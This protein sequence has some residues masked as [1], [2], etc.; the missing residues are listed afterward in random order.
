MAKITVQYQ[1]VQELEGGEQKNQLIMDDKKQEE[2]SMDGEKTQ[3]EQ[4]QEVEKIKVG[5]KEYSQEE[6]SHLVGLG[7]VGAE[8]ESKWNTKIDRLY[9]E[10][11]K[12]T[13]EREDYRKKVE[14]YETSRTKA[15]V[16]A[17]EELSPEE[18][19]KQALAEA[20]KLGLVHAGN[21]YQFVDAYLQAR[22]MKEEAEAIIT[23]AE[24]TGK[25]KTTTQ[26]L[27]AYMDQTGIKNVGLAYKSKFENELDAWKQKQLDGIKSGNM[28]TLD[29][30]RAGSKQ[31]EP[32][33]LDNLDSLSA[34]MK[35]Y[36]NRAS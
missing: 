21:V 28:E 26:E 34:A 12:A 6:L 1:V 5:E 35:S 2:K 22:D 20:E 13:Q 25:P 19:Q 23:E 9:P 29:A 11:T 7:E 31:P 14:E 27:F 15:K 36:F 17:G 24:E 18:A 30:S 33:K 32:V 10:F 3:P 16:A 4:T 8:L